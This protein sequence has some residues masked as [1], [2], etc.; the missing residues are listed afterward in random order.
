MP[1]GDYTLK[2]SNAYKLLQVRSTGV[3]PLRSILVEYPT[4]VAEPDKSSLSVP[5]HVVEFRLISEGWFI[6]LDKLL[7]EF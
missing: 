1:V 3:S 2:T 7:T 6:L 5:V 4:W